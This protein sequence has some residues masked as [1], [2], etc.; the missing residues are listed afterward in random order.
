MVEWPVILLWQ[1]A[2]GGVLGWLIW[3]LRR[4]DQPFY[5]LG[6]GLDWLVGITLVGL[7]LSSGFAL[8]RP[9]AL[10]QLA[11][12]ISYVLLAY[13]L[14]NGL[15]SGMLT[16]RTLWR[17]LA[18]AASLSAVISLAYWRPSVDMF[19]S[20]DFG[21]AVR[22]PQPLGHHN[23][24]GGYF[25]LALPLVVAL[26]IA[27]RGWRR[28][29]G[30]LGAGVIFVALYVSG[31]R[32]AALGSVVWV[33]V[34]VLSRLWR[35]RNAPRYQTGLGLG[36]LGLAIAGLLANPRVR[37]T[38][39]A[40]GGGG[41][42]SLLDFS[43]V[44]GPLI[45]RVFMAQAGLNM[46][47]NRPWLGV[48]PGN[49]S[50]LFNLYR[51]IEMGNGLDHVQQLHNTPIHLLGELG[52]LGLGLYSAWI[53]IMGW[54][55]WRLWRRLPAGADQTLLFGLGGSGL[56]YGVSS[57]TDYQ[58]ENIPIALTL[59]SGGVLLVV[60]AERSPLENPAPL[61]TLLRREASLV[62][63]AAIALLLRIWLPF[64]LA[65]ALESFAT[66]NVNE[67]QLSEAHQK[68]LQ[69]ADIVPW[70]PTAAALAAQNLIEVEP[71]I[72][73]L[74]DQASVRESIL[75]NLKAAYEAAPYDA[76]F[77]NNLAVRLLTEDPAQAEIFALRAAQ[78][79]PR[80]L[81][82]PYYLLGLT[83]LI[84]NKVEAAVTAFALEGL[85]S[86]GF[87]ALPFWTEEAFQPLLPAVVD[88]TLVLYNALLTK[89]APDQE[90]YAF[91]YEQAQL[92]RWWHDQP[93]LPPIA[94]VIPRPLVQALLAAETDPA[95]ALET[96]NS[97]IATA[98]DN[99]ALKMLQAWIDPDSYLEDLLALSIDEQEAAAMKD[100]IQANRTVQD[101]L[102]SLTEPSLIRKR[103][104][105]AFAYRNRNANNIDLILQPGP[106]TTYSLVDLLGLFGQWP[107]EFPPLDQLVE[108]IKASDLGLVHPTRNG[109]RLPEPSW[110]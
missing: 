19:T 45:D 24:V 5:P 83:Y 110:E 81:N 64:D 16:V 53:G 29:L 76:Y 57:L 26:A 61:P 49:I 94:G 88:K 70:D 6:Y 99:V 38:L 77:N 82:Y 42:D 98:P 4:F 66:H 15:G 96:L 80:T 91:L 108:A 73:N 97:A 31:S 71:V 11:L 85:I 12:V 56:A 103:Q 105:L 14:R 3:R 17:G 52:W 65:L 46:L 84:Q 44:D 58:L 2:F 10:W 67:G 107:R 47:G 48:G 51:P 95:A 30:V 33:A 68:W 72:E 28:W 87:T 1:G 50:R 8:F 100:H 13:A 78:L 92:L 63:L 104:G 9:V 18:I 90:G 39:Q 54:L 23:F 59:V 22:N 62:V 20:G 40:L 79:L 36:M 102:R 32:G 41:A 89:L 7:A 25:A 93:P 69:A 37:Q 109:Y 106:L 74:E 34:T 55:G 21:S 75:E 43:G 27:E 35:R 101:W 60:L 86:P